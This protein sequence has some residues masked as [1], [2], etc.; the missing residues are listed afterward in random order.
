MATY[1]VTSPDGKSYTVNAPEGTEKEALYR[2][3]QEQLRTQNRA[4]GKTT[5]EAVSS[6]GYGEENSY[7]SYNPSPARD[8]ADVLK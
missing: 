2:Y 4:A 7:E 6:T 1:N 5:Q 3:V 8:V